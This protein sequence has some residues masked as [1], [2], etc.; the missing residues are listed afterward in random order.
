MLKLYTQKT[1][2]LHD[3]DWALH[4]E[5]PGN[6]VQQ[7]RGNGEVSGVVAASMAGTVLAGAAVA[8]SMELLHNLPSSSLL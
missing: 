7:D 4:C 5:A 8:R 3:I 2:A 1:P 6:D